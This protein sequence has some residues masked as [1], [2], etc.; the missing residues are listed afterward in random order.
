MKIAFDENMPPVLVKVFTTLAKECTVIN[1]KFVSAAGYN[2]RGQN[3]IPWLTRFKK[4]GGEVLISGDRKMRSNLY[5]RRG[6]QQ[7]GLITFCFEPRWNDQN[8]F[9]KSAMLLKWWPKIQKTIA[10]SRPGDYWEIPFAWNTLDLSKLNIPKDK[11]EKKVSRKQTKELNNQTEEIPSA[12]S[13]D[14]LGD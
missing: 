5:E 8:F 4:S 12:T 14:D 9:V 3:D 6:V 7:L 10:E 11:E 1:A 2:Q 13:A